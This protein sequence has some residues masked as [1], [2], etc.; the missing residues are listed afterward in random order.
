[1]RRKWANRLKDGLGKERVVILELTSQV[2]LAADVASFSRALAAKLR[3]FAQEAPE[4]LPAP[5]ALLLEL[6]ER[7]KEGKKPVLQILHEPS[8]GVG[9]SEV[10]PSQGANGYWDEA[11]RQVRSIMEVLGDF[12]IQAG[13]RQKLQDLGQGLKRI[14]RDWERLGKEAKFPW[15]AGGKGG[16][17]QSPQTSEASWWQQYVTELQ[18]EGNTI[19]WALALAWRPQLQAWARGIERVASAPAGAPL[20][21]T[22]EAGPLSGRTVWE[23]WSESFCPVC[24]QPAGMASLDAEGRRFLGCAHCGTEWRTKRILCPFCGNEE[25]EKLSYIYLEGKPGESLFCCE[26]CGSYLKSFDER[27]GGKRSAFL[28]DL[29]TPEL[30]VLGHE[31]GYGFPAG[32]S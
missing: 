15:L 4:S 27:L 3:S 30:D 24:G 26:E 31:R 1:V 7:A 28:I 20:P 2:E 8:P 5:P 6:V 16:L 18:L 17:I 22:Q 21:G 19:S 13:P 32:Q 9:G 12:F 29:E 25:Q 14:G 11:A 10:L 23:G